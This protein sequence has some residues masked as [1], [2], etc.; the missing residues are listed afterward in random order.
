MID[1]IYI[2]YGDTDFKPDFFIPINNERCWVKPKGGLW[3]SPVDAKLGWKEWCERED[4]RPC[5]EENSFRFTLPDAKVFVID[6]VEKLKELPVIENPP[7]RSTSRLIDFEKCVE[8]GYDAIELNLSADHQLYW[9]LY[10]WDCDSILVMNPDK[11]KV[12][13]HTEVTMNDDILITR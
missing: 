7:Y 3:A 4:F 5:I 6:S 13:S 2:H 10:G 1:K 12:M 11:I 8:F 9:E